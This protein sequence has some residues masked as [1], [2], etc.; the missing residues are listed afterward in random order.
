MPGLQ[1]KPLKH[2]RGAYLHIDNNR[3]VIVD[4]KLPDDPYLFTLAHELKHHLCDQDLAK[5]F[6][7]DGNQNEIIEIGAEV[8]AAEFLYPENDFSKDLKFRGIEKGVCT[9]QDL[10]TLKH[11]VKTSLSY[12]GLRKRAIN[13]GYAPSTMPTSGWKQ[14]EVSLY[15]PPYRPH[16][17]LGK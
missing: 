5:A 6:C 15:G 2:L 10:V 14:I 12:A 16:H 17:R 3:H 1:G 9:Q 7:H 8:F 13:F 4:R 11:D